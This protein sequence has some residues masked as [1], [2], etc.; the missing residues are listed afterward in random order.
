[1]LLLLNPLE[2]STTTSNS[3]KGKESYLMKEVNFTQWQRRR[4]ESRCCFWKT[5]PEAPSFQSGL[6]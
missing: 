2:L 1:M 4:K 6:E 3:I 5:Y